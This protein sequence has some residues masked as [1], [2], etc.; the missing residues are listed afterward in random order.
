MDLIGQG[1]LKA[2]HLIAGASYSVW[3]PLLQTLQITGL[4]IVITLLIGLPLGLF[5]GLSQFRG[6]QLI[7][8]IVNSA[9]GLPPVVVGLFVS[10]LLWRSGVFGALGLMYTPG[11]MV[12]AEVIIA[13][14]LV[15][16][17]TAAT[18]KN[19]KEGIKW[20]IISLGASKLA[21]YRKMLIESRIGVAAAVIAGFGGI[22]SEVGAAMMV[23]GN[24]EGQTRVL[25][26]AIVLETRSGRF[27]TAI[28]LSV[29]L[30]SL[31]LLINIA[32]TRIQKDN[33]LWNRIWL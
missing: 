16:G 32:L 17:L 14:P 5:I 20:Q 15:I 10:L 11:A 23:G 26:T 6:K 27:E 3:A 25:T 30:L 19:M 1:I 13:L 7:L 24:I 31:T 33:K 29:I 18:I 9:M 4:A 21:L 28:A 22:I 8:S 2:F 12:I